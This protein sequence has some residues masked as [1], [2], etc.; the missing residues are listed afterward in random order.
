M[1]LDV[2][3]PAAPPKNPAI[4]AHVYICTAD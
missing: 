2:N 1:K 3:P 4:Y